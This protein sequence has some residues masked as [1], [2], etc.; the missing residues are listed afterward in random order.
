MK[1]LPIILAFFALTYIL[2]ANLNAESSEPNMSNDQDLKSMPESYWKEKLTPEQYHVCREGGTERPFSGKFVHNK[3][4]GTYTCAGCGQ[5]LF[6]ADTKFD[7][8]TG[9][10]SFSDVMNSKNVVLQ[11]DNS[12]GMHRIEVLCAKCGAHLGHVFND[13]IIYYYRQ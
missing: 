11:E 5:E 4:H 7:S 9:W 12:H 8:G 2:P 3:E 1:Y 10:P 13:G 6:S